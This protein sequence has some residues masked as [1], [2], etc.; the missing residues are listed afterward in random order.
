MLDRL[1]TREKYSLK[2]IYAFTSMRQVGKR[3]IGNEIIPHS[4]KW[5]KKKRINEYLVISMKSR[6]MTILIEEIQVAIEELL[7]S[8]MLQS[9]KTYRSNAD[10]ESDKICKSKRDSAKMVSVRVATKCGWS[11]GEME[12]A[13]PRIFVK[14]LI[15]I[16]HKT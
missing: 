10:Q 6:Q 9:F 5:R 11:R 2:E 16:M 15:Q 3:N 7:N 1:L 4:M 12:S 8:K 14:V 13:V